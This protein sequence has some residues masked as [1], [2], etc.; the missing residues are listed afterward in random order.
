[1]I[2][3]RSNKA[4]AKVPLAVRQLGDYN[5]IG[6][7]TS[8][9]NPS[10]RSSRPPSRLV[11][12]D[13]PLAAAAA[14]EKK[15]TTLTTSRSKKAVRPPSKSSS[16]EKR[17]KSSN[18]SRTLPKRK[19]AKKQRSDGVPTAKV[20]GKEKKKKAESQ[21]FPSSDSDSKHNS[22]KR[23]SKTMRMQL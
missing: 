8:M 17:N 14:A 18:A 6:N 22:I 11:E 1:M 5:G 10:K 20:K 12:M 3:K 13:L 16:Q 15:K 23:M 4:K 2:R 9:E 7:K 19:R 21:D